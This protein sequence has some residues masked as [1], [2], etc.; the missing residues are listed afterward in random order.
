VKPLLVQ[1]L[2]VSFGLFYQLA[3]ST[4]ALLHLYIFRISLI[5]FTFYTIALE[6]I[7]NV[8]IILHSYFISFVLSRSFH[9][10]S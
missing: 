1:V 4:F 2:L 8:N 5:V 7:Q 10:I 3:T 9:S 6:L